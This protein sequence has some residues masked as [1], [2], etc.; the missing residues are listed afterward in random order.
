MVG[1]LMSSA[2]LEVRLTHQ[3]PGTE[4]DV[5]FAGSGCTVLFGPSGA[6]KSTIAMAV[7]GLMR[8]DHL[9]LRVGG[10][11]LHDLPP[12]RRRIG[13]VFQ[14][15]RLFPHLSVL[16]NL[17]YGAR[18]ALPGDFP[19]SREEIMTML[20]IGALLKRRPATLSGGERQRVA[21]GRAL[22]SRPHMLVMDEPLASLD[23]ARKQDI[24]P[25]LRRLKA[26]GLP[27]LYV[28]HALQEMAYL[29]DDVVLL[30]TGRVRA[31]GSLGHISSD[32]ALS[33]GFGHEAGAVLE[34]VVSGHMPDR[35]LTILSCAG[36]EV[37]VPLQA[38]KPGTGLRVRIP[39]ADVIV[40]TES[41]GHISLHNILPVVMTDWQ[42]AYL[43]GKAGTT[44]EALVRLAL[45]GGHLLARVTR[46]AIQRLGLEPGRHVLAL[47]KSVAVDVLGP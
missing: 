45:P 3:F 37:L 35:G 15:A 18:R 10:L 1:K 34:A 28:T 6:G 7:A 22:L 26:A 43:Q 46:D 2:A 17:E 8:P 20:G 47:I 23:Q 12:E 27:M 19:L 38:L 32:P 4:I 33:G 44:Q 42:P 11:D 36:T 13:V 9:H 5:R 29:A 24:L 14:D 21:I 40:A 41:P 31:S 16:G 30:E 39:A 25:V